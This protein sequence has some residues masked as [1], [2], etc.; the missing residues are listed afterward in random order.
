M[1][2]RNAKSFGTRP[3]QMLGVEDAYIAYCLDEAGAFLLSQ[4]T[5]PAYA[6]TKKKPINRNKKALEALRAVGAQVNI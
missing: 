6:E 2:C 5:P 3:S 4:K 1:L